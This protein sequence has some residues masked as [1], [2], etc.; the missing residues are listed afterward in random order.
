MIELRLDEIDIFLNKL[1]GE[2]L[3]VGHLQGSGIRSVL[4]P[5]LY[6]KGGIVYARLMDAR[7]IAFTGVPIYVCKYKMA[8]LTPSRFVR[9]RM[10]PNGHSYVEMSSLPSNIK[11]DN[12]W[13]NE[14]VYSLGDEYGINTPY[15]DYI[16]S[17]VHKVLMRDNLAR[18]LYR[19]QQG[20]SRS[21]KESV[22]FYNHTL[23]NL[24]DQLNMDI[25]NMID[26]E[27]DMKVYKEYKERYK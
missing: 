22:E 23:I 13:P 6:E 12:F 27:P 24:I 10:E 26:N 2:L 8:K 11:L 3:S 14:D 16:I 20:I 7:C 21:V 4:V 18:S 1:G 9:I 25:D 17:L 15:E 5:V 19:R